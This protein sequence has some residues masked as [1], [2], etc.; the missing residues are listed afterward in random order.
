[1]QYI[2]F[3]I[4]IVYKRPHNGSQLE[5]THVAVNKLIKLALYVTDFNTYTCERLQ[6][7]KGKQ[8]LLVLTQ[9]PSFGFASCLYMLFCREFTSI[10]CVFVSVS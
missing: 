7:L 9:P 6:A 2:I 5:L 3:P 1:M 4:I 8:Q 10:W